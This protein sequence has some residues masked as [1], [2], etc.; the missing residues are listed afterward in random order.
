VNPTCQALWDATGRADQAAFERHAAACPACAPQQ[1]SH[2]ALSRTLATAALPSLGA[3][4]DRE[5]AARIRQET[6]VVPLSGFARIAAIAYWVVFVAVLARFIAAPA[7]AWAPAAWPLEHAA[8]LVPI[9]FAAA[10]WL[11]PACRQVAAVVR[12]ALGS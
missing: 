5:V 2:R 6:R 7:R 9:G 3:G 8:W 12:Q 1:R 10:M 11:R 4:F